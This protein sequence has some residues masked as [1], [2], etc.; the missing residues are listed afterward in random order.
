MGFTVPG[1]EPVRYTGEPTP[2]RA[3]DEEPEPAAEP[4]PSLQ[5]EPGR[6]PELVPA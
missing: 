2:T 3:P 1:G 5:P 6:E 4:V